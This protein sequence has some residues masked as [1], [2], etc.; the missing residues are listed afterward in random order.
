VTNGSFDRAALW[1]RLGG[2]AE[3]LRELVVIFSQESPGLLHS[4]GAAIEERSFQD[5]Q[6][7]SHKLKGSALQFSGVKA[8]ALAASLEQMG[9]RRKLD[10]A[11]QVFSELEQEV[12]YLTRSL[13]SMASEKELRW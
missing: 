9:V 7:L 6:K 4:I 5:V 11:D 10:G 12:A 8:A 2:D 1:N 13:K 3:L